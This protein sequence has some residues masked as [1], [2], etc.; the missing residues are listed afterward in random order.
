MNTLFRALKFF[1]PDVLRVVAVL[2]LTL[3][4]IALSV[5][6]PWPLA[7]IVDSVLGTKPLPQAVPDFIKSS[8]PAAQVG[9][10]IG[11]LLVVHLAH[12]SLSAIYN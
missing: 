12:A 11:A 2:G 3:L 7:L 4:S 10:L 8:D 9:M 1:R 5:L 6:K